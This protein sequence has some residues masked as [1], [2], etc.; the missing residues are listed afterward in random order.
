MILKFHLWFTCKL[1][2]SLPWGI[3]VTFVQRRPNGVRPRCL[4][5]AGMLLL[6]VLPISSLLR[7]YHWLSL[8]HPG[9]ICLARG[10]SSLNHSQ[11]LPSTVVSMSI[12]RFF[13]INARHFFNV[14]VLKQRVG[15]FVSFC[16][17]SCKSRAELV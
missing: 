1:Y 8:S 4:S 9:G 15:H 7:E 2:P 12:S 16:S 17:S 14:S 3:P 5:C 10:L 13:K 11:V 6:S